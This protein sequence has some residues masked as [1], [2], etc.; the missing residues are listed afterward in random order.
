MG[1][2]IKMIK[3]ERILIAADDRTKIP[4]YLHKGSDTSLV[5]L[6]HGFGADHSHSTISGIA[7]YLSSRNISVLTFDLV[8]HGERRGGNPFDILSH[9]R[10]IGIIVRH[11]TAYKNIILVG[12]SFGA[13]TAAIA[14]AAVS[15]IHALVT[16]NGFFTYGLP[17][18]KYRKIYLKFRVSALFPTVY[19]KIWSFVKRGI[20][21][22][23]IQIP[24]LV[25]YA[26][27]DTDVSSSESIR[28]HES[29]R[30]RKKILC[31]PKANHDL[32]R[33]GNT[34]YAGKAIAD[35]MSTQIR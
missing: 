32:T 24:T 16:I 30:C 21:V 19:R 33:T 29:L 12:G 6:L 13:L 7:S 18:G 2:M 4:V 3:P 25:L 8:G 23:Q 22:S 10:D 20:R 5:M 35:W 27:S 34:E 17:L 11:F 15:G 1:E 26:D 14:A 31:I 28:F 9:V